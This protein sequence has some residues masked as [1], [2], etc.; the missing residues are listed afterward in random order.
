MGPEARGPQG[1]SEPATQEPGGELRSRLG[2]NEP[3]GQGLQLSSETPPGQRGPR[4]HIGPRKQTSHCSADCQGQWSWH[5]VC[6]TR[7]LL[8]PLAL[9]RQS[10]TLGTACPRAGSLTS[11]PRLRLVP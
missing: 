9:C 11:I 8:V 10:P 2:Q 6:W 5:D 3:A 1:H 4:C 7:P